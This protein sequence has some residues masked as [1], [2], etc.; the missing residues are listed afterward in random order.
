MTRSPQQGLPFPHR[1]LRDHP[2]E[3]TLAANPVSVPETSSW[4]QSCCPSQARARTPRPCLLLHTSS[5]RLAEGSRSTSWANWKLSSIHNDPRVLSKHLIAS[6]RLL[7]YVFQTMRPFTGQ[8]KLYSCTLEAL[9][10]V[11][12]HLASDTRSHLSSS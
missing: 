4:T 1:L 8:K 7:D 11:A 12:F 5:T 9:I 3:S 2:E 6:Y 10:A